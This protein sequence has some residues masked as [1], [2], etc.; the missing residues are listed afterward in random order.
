[1]HK[2]LYNHQ[3]CLSK[4]KQN[5]YSA[6]RQLVMVQ[7][8]ITSPCFSNAVIISDLVKLVQA[9]GTKSKWLQFKDCRKQA[10]V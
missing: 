1:M 6:C 10:Q 9:G 8:H 4:K 3:Q 7:H 5:D 2:C